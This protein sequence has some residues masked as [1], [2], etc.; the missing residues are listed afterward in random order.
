MM[1]SRFQQWRLF[2]KPVVLATMLAVSVVG[3]PSA[4]FAAS[5]G[6]GEARVI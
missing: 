2:S 1:I 3:I 6:N 5:E 4:I